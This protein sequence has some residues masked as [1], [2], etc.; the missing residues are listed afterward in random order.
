MPCSWRF[1]PLQPVPFPFSGTDF[2]TPGRPKCLT[3]ARFARLPCNINTFSIFGFS[4]IRSPNSTQR[5]PA[6]SMWARAAAVKCNAQTV[7]F[8]IYTTRGSFVTVDTTA[9]SWSF[10]CF[11]TD[12]RRDVDTGGQFES[13]KHIRW[14]IVD[15]AALS[16]FSAARAYTD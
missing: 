8:G 16:W 14:A 4:R 6:V 10:W 15:S 5:P 13:D 1:L 7:I 3:T 12:A 2:S 11:A 9:I